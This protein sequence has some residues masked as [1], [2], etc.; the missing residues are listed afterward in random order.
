MPLSS[1]V[2]SQH[3]VTLN[4]VVPNDEAPQWQSLID[5]FETIHP[6]ILI[7]LVNLRDSGAIKPQDPRAVKQ[8]YIDS[9]TF[10]QE[11]FYDLVFMDVIWVPEF[12]ENGLIQELQLQPSDA[13]KEFL[14]DDVKGGTYQ[15][16]LYRLPV[17]SD[18]GWLYYRA[19]LLKDAGV[20]PPET[21]EQLSAISQ[22]L[23]N[24]ELPWG[25]LWQGRQAEAIVAMFVEVLHG[26]GGFWIQPET[27]SVGLDQ[28]EAIAAVRFLHGT[29]FGKHPISPKALTAQR[30]DE[31]LESFL[32]GK[33]AF[34]RNW[35]YVLPRA[36]LTD[37]DIRNKI[38]VKPMVHASGYTGAGCQGGWGLGIAQRTKHPDEAWQAVQFFT[39]AAAQRKLF[40]AASNGLPTRRELFQDPQLVK[41]YSHYPA[42]LHFFEHQKPHSVVLRPAIP[43][44]AQASCILQKYLHTILTQENP[45]IEQEMKDA[46]RDTQI[47]LEWLKGN[48][49]VE[50]CPN[51]R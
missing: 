29:M 37:S 46:A 22:K 48:P 40:L 12:A 45:N 16:K 47:L 24:Q 39:S 27:R 15:N 8:L 4:F 26:H 25:Y 34:L 2:R 13:E 41:R 33:A 28:P 49:K 10:K 17:R 30:E 1:L 42:F 20:D 51:D 14:I 38:G 5:E 18:V 23:Q 19:D 21:F 43:Q 32:E 11:P 35:S 44:Y 7:D 6:N 36:N 50:G 9:L 3:S 31:T